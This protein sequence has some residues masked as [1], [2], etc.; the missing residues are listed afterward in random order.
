MDP[1]DFWLTVTPQELILMWDNND[2]TFQECPQATKEL[3]TKFAVSNPMKFQHWDFNEYAVNT[4]AVL[5]LNNQNVLTE[6]IIRSIVDFYKLYEYKH[7]ANTGSTT[8]VVSGNFLDSDYPI[9]FKVFCDALSV[10]KDI[11]AV[12]QDMTQL[13]LNLNLYLNDN[14]DNFSKTE[15]PY[16]WIRSEQFLVINPLAVNNNG[17]TYIPLGVWS[18]KGWNV[19]PLIGSVKPQFIA[20]NA[21]MQSGGR[22]RKQVKYTKSRH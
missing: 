1:E 5:D 22:R 6:A 17:Y 8:S 14:P 10:D 20:S 16:G 15:N 21:L 4:S 2:K 9:M 11:Q 3:R 18:S 19:P 12:N 7:N 13:A